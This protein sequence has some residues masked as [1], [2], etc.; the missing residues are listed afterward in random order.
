M[1]GRNDMVGKEGG[2]VYYSP[3]EF[4][5]N[6]YHGVTVPMLAVDVLEMVERSK[7]V[8]LRYYRGGFLGL[9]YGNHP[10][11]RIKVMGIAVGCRY[12]CI[13]D[14]DYLLV[15]LD[16]CS[17]SSGFLQCKCLE[18]LANRFGLCWGSVSGQKLKMHGRFNLYYCELEVDEVE[19]VSDMVAE[20]EHWEVS[21][22]Y[23]RRLSVPWVEPASPETNLCSYA[24]GLRAGN[25]IALPK[26]PG[27]KKEFLRALLRQESGKTR[28][29]ELLYALSGALE[30]MAFQELKF[31]V[32]LDQLYKLHYSGL[33]SC[34]P[35]NNKVDLRPLK[36]LYQYSMRRISTLINLQCST[37]RIDYDYVRG[38]LNHPQ[39]T[40]RAIVD[41]FKES[42]RVIARCQRLLSSWWIDAGNKE[43]S[44]I[45]FKYKSDDAA[46]GVSKP[47]EH[48]TLIQ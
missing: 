9:L 45:Y 24:Q 23:R 36:S 25:V 17:G 30:N 26:V 48:I 16:D 44:V 27:L 35:N 1:V 7:E 22:K 14:N 42:L 11:N 38:K 8:C 28:T 5:K 2:L 20:I 37:G 6:R 10:L 46:L 4:H 15:K 47:A 39:F 29:T 3:L 31:E 33:V 18:S 32:L 19:L 40:E 41:I 34:Q 12:R 13:G 43:F 21:I